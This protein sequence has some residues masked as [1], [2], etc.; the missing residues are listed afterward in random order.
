MK[1]V[2]NE[3]AENQIDFSQKIAMAI[4]GSYSPHQQVSLLLNI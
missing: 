1:S 4:A 2:F 3:E